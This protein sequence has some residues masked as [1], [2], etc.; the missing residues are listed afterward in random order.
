MSTA[1]KRGPTLVKE[2]ERTARALTCAYCSRDSLTVTRSGLIYIKAAHGG[3]AHPSA[4]TIQKLLQ[5]SMPHLDIHTVRDIVRL[6]TE[7]LENLISA[8]TE[9]KLTE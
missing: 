2:G 9:N 3:D 4:I 1:L 6:G 8:A 5:W 7:E